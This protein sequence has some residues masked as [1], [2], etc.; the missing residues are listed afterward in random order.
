MPTLIMMRSSP[1]AAGTTQ[2]PGRWSCPFGPLHRHVNRSSKRSRLSLRELLAAPRLVQAHFLALDFARVARDEPRLRE[3]GFQGG[4]VFDERPG[5]PV[6]NCAG[7]SRL[8]AAQHGHADVESAE[9]IGELERLAHDHAPGLAREVAIEGLLV[10]DDRALAGLE[11][12]AR[13][14]VLAAARSV[15]VFTDHGQ[16][17]RA[18][19]CC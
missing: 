4:V 2:G 9:V 1:P 14:R 16:I 12:D 18:L 5:D 19:G 7:L 13:D 15:V 6:A 3:D 8:A 11:E 10:H 17:S